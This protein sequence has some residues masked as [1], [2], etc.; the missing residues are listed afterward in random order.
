MVINKIE[1]FDG[2]YSFLSNFYGMILFGEYAKEKA[3]IT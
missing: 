1:R 3:K 2:N